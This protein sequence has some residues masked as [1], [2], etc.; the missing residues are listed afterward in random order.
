MKRPLI[1]SLA[2][3]TVCLGAFLVLRV[4][5]EPTYDGRSLSQWLRD[6][7]SVGSAKDRRAREAIRGLGTNAIPFLI[8]LLSAHDSEVTGLLRRFVANQSAA[9][10]W[11][12]E[13]QKR[14]NQALEGFAALGPLAR[15]AIPELMRLVAELENQD[16]RL[17][18]GLIGREAAPPLTEML[19]NSDWRYRCAAIFCLMQ[20]DYA[21]VE[22]AVPGLLKRMSDDDWRVRRCAGYSLEHYFNPQP[23]MRKYY[24]P[25]PPVLLQ[26]TN[27][28]DQ[29][30][31]LDALVS[32]LEDKSPDV[33]VMAVGLL[34]RLGSTAKPAFPLVLQSLA[35]E[36]SRVRYYASNALVLID[37]DAAAKLEVK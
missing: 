25:V 11:L 19:R 8:R 15:P 32:R 13:P 22:R 5:R 16:A 9:R 36:N 34:G 30:V 6:C 7:D 29:R 37:P 2:A 4:H 27:K 23:W 33:R 24:N 28:P 35:D 1:I 3:I 20:L 26:S 14:R 21:S 31:F 17:A 10:I 18:I 12:P